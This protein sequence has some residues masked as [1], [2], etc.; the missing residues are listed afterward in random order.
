MTI[1]KSKSYIA[2]DEY[3]EKALE[4]LKK[5]E[6]YDALIKEKCSKSLALK[7]I[8]VSRAN[9]TRWKKRYKEEGLAGLEDYS[10]RPKTIRKHEWT[11]EMSMRVH[12]LRNL[13]PFFGKS[14]PS[15]FSFF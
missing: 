12:N 9:L 3:S 7:V 4:R 6:K 8:E 1:R 10:R 15:R 2:L 14:I 5:I 11:H 13:Y